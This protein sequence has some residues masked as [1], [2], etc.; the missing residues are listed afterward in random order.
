M[1]QIELKHN[2]TPLTRHHQKT[3]FMMSMKRAIYTRTIHRIAL[4]IHNL[5]IEGG[6]THTNI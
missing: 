1:S 3:V 2:G 6:E 5:Q 4:F